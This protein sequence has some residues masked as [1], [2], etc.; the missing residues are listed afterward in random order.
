MASP[1]PRPRPTS[2]RLPLWA[3]GLI[4]LICLAAFV[5]SGVWLYRTMRTVAADW[6]VTDAPQFTPIATTDISTAADELAAVLVTTSADGISTP[7]PSAAINNL[8]P[9]TWTGVER[10][11]VLMLGIDQRC[12]ETGPTRTDSMMLL[13]MDPVGKTAGMLSLPRD[14]WVE[15]PGFGV[16]RINQAHYFGEGFEYPGGGPALAKETVE[17][18]LGIRIDYYVTINF[19]VFTQVVDLLG[20][21]EVD[22]PEAISDPKYPDSCYGYDPFTIEPGIQQFNGAQALKFARTR[23]TAGGDVDRAMRQQMVVLAVRDAALAQISSLLLQAPQLWQTLQDNVRTNMTLDEAMQLALLVQEIPRENINRAV[24]DFKYVYTAVTP[25]GQEVLVPIRENIRALRDEL[26]APPTAP[27]AV[28]DDL[29]AK[30]ADESA[31]VAIYNGTPVVG[32][33]SST[34][35]YL[36]PFGFN[37]T[38]VGNADAATYASTQI[39]DFGEHP[40][41]TQYLVQVL[42]VPPLNVVAGSKPDGDYDV[43]VI[44]G[45]DWEVP[46]E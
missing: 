11:T 16:N 39:I 42:G 17:A 21:I 14:L 27:T 28:I 33:A 18:T 37:I 45:N 26:F 44:V 43:L 29:P 31:R 34:E 13:T 6:Q 24:I 3:V 22:V 20:G 9:P 4:G 36:A 1:S 38:T 8:L 35:T 2:V 23:A 15:I 7:T 25:D 32:L 10:V 30:M 12:D 5:G 40:Y 19:D 41:T 46:S